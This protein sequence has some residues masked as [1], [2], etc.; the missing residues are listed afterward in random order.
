MEKSDKYGELFREFYRQGI[1]RRLSEPRDRPTL[2]EGYAGLMHPYC[3]ALQAWARNPSHQ[4]KERVRLMAEAAERLERLPQQVGVLQFLAYAYRMYQCA[5]DKKMN[6]HLRRWAERLRNWI[7]YTGGEP[8][9]SR[10]GELVRDNCPSTEQLE[11]LF[12]TIPYH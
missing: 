10:Y 11:T 2:P 1:A 7:Q 4:P 8:Y 5:M 9:Q 12:D 6:D 3:F